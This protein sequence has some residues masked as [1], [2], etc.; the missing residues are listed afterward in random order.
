MAKIT[1]SDAAPAEK[2]HY[3]FSGAEFDIS[4]KGSFETDS[5]D[6]LLDAE[7]HPWLVV[8]YPKVELVQGA[9]AEQVLPQDDP[10]S[11]ENYDGNDPDVARA[12]EEAKRADFENPV[13]IEAGLVQTTPVES[14]AVAETLAADETTKTSTKIAKG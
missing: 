6:V 10:M 7:V 11:A 14:G 3:T 2:V 4:G 1:H 8:T 13:A 12:A 9:Y 5:P